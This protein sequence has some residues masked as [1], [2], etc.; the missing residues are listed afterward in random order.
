MTHSS[1]FVTTYGFDFLCCSAI[2]GEIFPLKTPVPEKEG[3]Q[4]K[5]SYMG[6]GNRTNSHENE[7][8]NEHRQCAAIRNHMGKR[9]DDKE[10]VSNEG[11][12]YGEAN[13]PI[14]SPVRISDVP[15]EKRCSEAP[16]E[17]LT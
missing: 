11:C 9:S 2:N 17:L 6:G 14:P 7:S 15:A 13:C 16:V 4:N 10:N 8:E 3:S 1:P 5:Y 12:A